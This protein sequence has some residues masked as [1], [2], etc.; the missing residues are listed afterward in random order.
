M[1]SPKHLLLVEDDNAH[2]R[3]VMLHLANHA[4]AFEVSR[5]SD[6]EQAL[7]FARRQ[8]RFAEAPRPDLILLDLNL[9]RIHGH[10]VLRRLKADPDLRA[11]PI[12]V[13]STS[14]AEFDRWEAYRNGVNSY[15]VKPA[16]YEAFRDMVRDLSAYWCTWNQP[17]A[18]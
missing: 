6:G 12:I 4:E 16:D 8:G 2:A 18:A 3:L 15:L 5:V 10:E 9:P 7:A 13:L 14:S 1:S 17:P 11:I